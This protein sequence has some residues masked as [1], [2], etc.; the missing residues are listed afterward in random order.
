MRRSIKKAQVDEIHSK[1][2]VINNK[3]LLEVCASSFDDLTIPPG[4]IRI[5]SPASVMYRPRETSL[6]CVKAIFSGP[7]R[8]D[9]DTW[10]GKLP[11]TQSTHAGNLNELLTA[12]RHALEQFT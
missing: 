5:K 2:A 7:Y 3:A 4:W 10:Q 1:Q 6:P 12:T 11:K 8:V 9:V